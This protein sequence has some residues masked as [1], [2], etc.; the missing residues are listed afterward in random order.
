[1]INDS[2]W[3]Y[4][5]VLYYFRKSE[6]FHPTDLDAPVNYAYHSTGEYWNIEHHH[7]DIPLKH[8]FRNA[9]EELGYNFTD[10]NSPYGR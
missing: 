5:I 4:K 7:P 3:Y 6:D 1:M 10:Y 9:N 2:S 8:V